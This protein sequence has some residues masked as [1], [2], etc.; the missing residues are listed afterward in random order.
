VERED[1]ID[2][3]KILVVD[4][5]QIVCDLLDAALTGRGYSCTT[6][7]S[8]RRAVVELESKKYDVVL[9]D[10][11]LPGMSGIDVLHEIWVN[12]PETAAI[13][14]TAID[15]TSTAVEAMK[16]G[17]SDYIVKPFDIDRVIASIDT[18]LAVRQPGDKSSPEMDAIAGVIE[19]KLGL[20]AGDLETITQ[21]AADVARELG[22]PEKEVRSWKASRIAVDRSRD[23]AVRSSIKKLK[24]D[25][26]DQ[27]T[28]K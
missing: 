15:D 9:L 12:H 13:M 2:T 4:D 7:L 21:R 3:K 5:E 20:L 8:G 27:E 11:R 1:S 14:I 23:R 18:A 6:V 16:W 22:V 25:I 17:A 24:R 10:I 26:L 19:A 28:E